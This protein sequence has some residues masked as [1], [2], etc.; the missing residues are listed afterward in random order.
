MPREGTNGIWSVRFRAGP[1][2][3]FLSRETA[4]PTH[5]ASCTDPGAGPLPSA[6]D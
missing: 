4:G 5:F 1:R 2:G 3:C 6:L